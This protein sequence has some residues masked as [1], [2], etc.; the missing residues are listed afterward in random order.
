MESV[1]GLVQGQWGWLTID[2][3]QTAGPYRLIDV[4]SPITLAPPLSE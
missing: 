1:P 4:A 2:E 3:K